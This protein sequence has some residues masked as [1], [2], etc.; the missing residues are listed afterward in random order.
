MGEQWEFDMRGEQGRSSGDV[1]AQNASLNGEA[2][3]H[4]PLSSCGAEVVPCLGVLAAGAAQ[5]TALDVRFKTRT[6]PHGFGL[7]KTGGEFANAR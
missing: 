3:A 5:L 4:P 2:M 1:R 7:G 6:Q